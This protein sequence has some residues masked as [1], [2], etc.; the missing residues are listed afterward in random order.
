MSYTIAQKISVNASNTSAAREI[1][2]IALLSYSMSG[3]FL[4]VFAAAATT[5]Q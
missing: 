2:I 1:N 3:L 5:K 4:S